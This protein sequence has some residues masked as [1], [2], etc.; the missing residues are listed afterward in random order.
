M[1]LTLRRRGS[2]ED[3]LLDVLAVPG[4]IYVMSSG[5]GA[6][7]V[8]TDYRKNSISGQGI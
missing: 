1:D 3:E 4:A 2:A 5:S 7:D 8:D 6:N